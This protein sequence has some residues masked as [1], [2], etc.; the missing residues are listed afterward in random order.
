M[1]YYINYIEEYGSLF[2]ALDRG[3]VRFQ[4][5]KLELDMKNRESPPTKPSIEDDPKVELKA[6]PPHPMYLFLGKGDTLLVI[7]ASDLKGHQVE[8]FVEVLNRFKYLFGGLLHIRIP[9]SIFSHKIILM[10]DNKPSIEHHRRL[11]PPMKEVVKR[12][13]LSG[14]MLE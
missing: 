1:N 4:P 7:I 8:S 12:K 10:P 6:L 9:P 13:L 2:A 5:K 11:N 3:N 14:L